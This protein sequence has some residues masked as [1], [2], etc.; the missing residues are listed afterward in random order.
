MARQVLGEETRRG[1]ALRRH[2]LRC[3]RIW[4][5]DSPPRDQDVILSCLSALWS[6][7]HGLLHPCCIAAGLAPLGVQVHSTGIVHES[8]VPL[9]AEMSVPGEVLGQGLCVLGQGL[10]VY[11][12][13]HPL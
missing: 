12:G 6:Q 13:T 11:A 10:C 5:Q 8:C 3:T 7:S 1:S 4:G 2:C 9:S